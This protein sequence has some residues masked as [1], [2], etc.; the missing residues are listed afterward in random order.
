MGSAT[1]KA[2]VTA[3]I[4]AAI[5]A[6]AAGPAMAVG[7]NIGALNPQV[8]QTPK[9]AQENTGTIGPFPIGQLTDQLPTGQVTGPL[10]GVTGQAQQVVPGSVLPGLPQLG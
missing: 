7:G 5:V 3:G 9:V 4:G 6:G 10:E 8:P 1:R 2:A